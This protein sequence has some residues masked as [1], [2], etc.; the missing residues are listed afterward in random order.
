MSKDYYKIL[1]VER[2][3][4]TDQI[5]QAYRKIAIKHHPDKGGGAESEAKF[6]DASEAYSVLSDSA[7]RTQYDQFG[8]DAFSGGGSGFSGGGFDFNN[9]NASDFAGFE[10][11]FGSFF[12]G[13]RASSRRDVTRGS[14]VEVMIELA[15]EEAVF[16]V[17]REISINVDTKCEDCEGTGSTNKKLKTCSKCNGAGQV[18]VQRQT[19]FGA[20]R[21]QTICN[22]CNG[23][24]QVPEAVCKN[25]HG[26]GRV[27]QVQKIPLKIPA[28]IDDGQTIRVAGRGGAGVRGGTAGDLYVVVRVMPSREYRR[29]G[30]NLYKTMTVPYTKM[31]L[32]G[33]MTI[34]TV[35]GE[36]KLKIP[37]A[38]QGGEVFKIRGYGVPMLDKKTKG[39]L[40]VQLD[41]EVPSRLTIK[42]RRLLEDLDKED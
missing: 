9:F 27:K 33:T 6:K 20:M 32:G 22:E 10:D 3:A 24:G 30:H 39:D 21:Q 41:I 18:T 38:T 17:E 16:G 5:K 29:D 11:I 36:V 15:F 12:G 23:T 31:V 7:K 4:T 26:G 19:M 37:P 34:G 35:H 13:G 42:Q 2:G 40:F 8:S 28:G 1:G 14:D 25:C